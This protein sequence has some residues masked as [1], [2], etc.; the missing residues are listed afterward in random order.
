M[1]KDFALNDLNDVYHNLLRGSNMAG[2]AHIELHEIY[3]IVKMRPVIRLFTSLTRAAKATSFTNASTDPMQ[4]LQGIRYEARR[5]SETGLLAVQQL[6]GM[7]KGL[8]LVS[9]HHESPELDLHSNGGL[10]NVIEIYYRTLKFV[11]EENR[12]LLLSEVPKLLTARLVPLPPTYSS[13][14]RFEVDPHWTSHQGY[15]IRD[16]HKVESKQAV[17]ASAEQRPS[18]GKPVRDQGSTTDIQGSTT[19]CSTLGQFQNTQGST[20]VNAS[21]RI[22]AQRCR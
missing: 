13:N 19:V 22:M 8:T 20:S 21:A 4:A 6:A 14:T 16:A 17:K 10:L 15:S 12:R 2:L 1:N 9:L 11:V 7:N 5:R 3:V 18:N